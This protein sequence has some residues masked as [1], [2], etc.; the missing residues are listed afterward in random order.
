MC[1]ADADVHML[2][3][4]RLFTIRLGRHIVRRRHLELIVHQTLQSTIRRR[5]SVYMVII[6][7]TQNLLNI[8]YAR[9]CGYPT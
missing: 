2:I 8:L 1:A 3:D 4:R 7:N 6:Y 9:G 5:R